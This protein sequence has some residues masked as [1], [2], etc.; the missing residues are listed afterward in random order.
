[1][2][3]WSVRKDGFEKVVLEFRFEGWVG[4]LGVLGM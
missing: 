1:M 4:V 2:I 3:V